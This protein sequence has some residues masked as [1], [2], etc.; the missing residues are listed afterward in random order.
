MVA[1]LR[2]VTKHSHCRRLD[3]HP[4]VSLSCVDV[5]LNVFPFLLQPALLLP[6]VVDALEQGLDLWQ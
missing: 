2:A 5:G 3:G 4:G 6:L 1:K